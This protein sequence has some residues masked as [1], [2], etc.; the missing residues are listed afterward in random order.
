M[1]VLYVGV[2]GRMLNVERRTSKVGVANPSKFDIRLFDIRHST[3]YPPPLP[4][5]SRPG[6]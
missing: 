4:A 3:L 1:I 6:R 5:A 2:S